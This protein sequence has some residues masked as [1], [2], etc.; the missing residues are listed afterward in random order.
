MI[1]ILMK[2]IN[3]SHREISYCFLSFP[4]RLPHWACTHRIFL[5]VILLVANMA[6]LAGFFAVASIVRF[7]G[8]YVCCV[9]SNVLSK[10]KNN[11]FGV[12]IGGHVACLLF[13]CQ[14]VKSML[15]YMYSMYGIVVGR[16]ASCE[17]LLI[18]F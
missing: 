3:N 6:I 11:M 15:Y 7:E 17:T 8:A 9:K 2:F 4:S 1:F 14:H 16:C 13:I 10:A 12:K 18:S 5:R